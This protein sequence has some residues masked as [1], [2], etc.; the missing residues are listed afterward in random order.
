[1]TSTSTTTTTP[2]GSIAGVLTLILTVSALCSLTAVIFIALQDAR[3]EAAG[4]LAVRSER[5]SGTLPRKCEE[6]YNDGTG[7]WIECMGVGLK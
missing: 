1:M 6:F 4:T 2:S 5:I 7:R 3:L